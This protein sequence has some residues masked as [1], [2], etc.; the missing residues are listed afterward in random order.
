MALKA[1]RQTLHKEGSGIQL[2]PKENIALRMPCKH[3]LK[4]ELTSAFMRGHFVTQD[5]M[6]VI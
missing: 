4:G 1:A 5:E 2:I 6:N 3:Y